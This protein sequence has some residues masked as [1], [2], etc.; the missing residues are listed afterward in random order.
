[1]TPCPFNSNNFTRL[2]S[3]IALP[4]QASRAHSSALTQMLHNGPHTVTPPF[5]PPL[6]DAGASRA[7]VNSCNEWGCRGCQAFHKSLGEPRDR[8]I[9]TPGEEIGA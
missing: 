6:S 1:M 9:H 3:G 4:R 8:G 2:T 7:S 5:C